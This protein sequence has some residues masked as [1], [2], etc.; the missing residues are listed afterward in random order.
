MK[1]QTRIKNCRFKKKCFCIAF[2]CNKLN[3]AELCNPFP[4]KTAVE[5]IFF[6]VL[7][8]VSVSLSSSGQV[9]LYIFSKQ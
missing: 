6:M 5:A 1:P 8:S 7:S 3:N 9:G 4:L 2:Y